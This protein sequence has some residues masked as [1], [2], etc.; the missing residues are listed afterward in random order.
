[1]AINF[2]DSPTVGST[3]TSGGVVWQ[4]DGSKWI[5]ASTSGSGFLPLNGG[6]MQGPLILN[7]DPATALGAATKEY[8]DMSGAAGVGAFGGF[9]N[10]LRNGTFD[11]W[12]RGNLT[13]AA[14]TATTVADGWYIL[15]TGAA[16]TVQRVT[17]NSNQPP[18]AAVMGI[19]GA[20]GLTTLQALTR[21]ES[22]VAAPLA[23]LTCTF[24]VWAFSTVAQTPQLQISHPATADT[25][26]WNTI[27]V[28]P[29]NMQPLP[30]STWTRLAYTFNAPIASALN[31]LQASVIFP[32]SL[33]AGTIYMGAADLRATPG[34]SVGLC[35]NPPPPELRPIPVEM[36]FCQRYYTTGQIA[37]FVPGVASTAAYTSAYYKT[38]MR[39]TPTWAL[40]VNNSNGLTAAPTAIAALQYG[41][42]VTIGGTAAATGPVLINCTF[43]SSAEL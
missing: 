12:Q 8:V 41:E 19:V 7:A 38:R 20:A 29:V 21:I 30:A 9:I 22:L 13:A 37:S 43:S 31:G 16:P 42:G 28:G 18:G 2:P 34:L 27:D 17:N 14:G 25:S 39:A 35:A 4:W 5:S 11:V 36:A 23:G 6:T 24:Q 3:F 10:K 26:P 40:I 1:M 33:G 32:G 15:P